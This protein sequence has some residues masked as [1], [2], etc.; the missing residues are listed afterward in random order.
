VHILGEAGIVERQAG[1]VVT[2]HEPGVVAVGQ[3]DVVDWPKL[4]D[5]GEEWKGVV[6]P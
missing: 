5:F 1:L 6:P 4:T 2:Y 3:R